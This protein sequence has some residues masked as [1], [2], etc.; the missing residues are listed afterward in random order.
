MER[1]THPSSVGGTPDYFYKYTTFFF[2]Y[3]G[4]F[5]FFS[6]Y[7]FISQSFKIISSGTDDY[8]SGDEIR[9]VLIGTIYET[10]KILDIYN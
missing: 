7:L 1:K 8:R 10:F 9:P 3:S 2:N 6:A 4:L 5:T